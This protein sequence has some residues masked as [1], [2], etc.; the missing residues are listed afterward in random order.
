MVVIVI[1]MLIVMLVILLPIIV[2]GDLPKQRTHLRGVRGCTSDRAGAGDGL[3]LRL[4]ASGR[5]LFRMKYFRFKE[6]L[7]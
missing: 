7:V 1:V 3:R 6:F 4:E 2:L 5:V